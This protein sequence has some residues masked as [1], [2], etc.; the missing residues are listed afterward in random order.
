MKT[1]THLLLLAFSFHVA[2]AQTFPYDVDGQSYR[3]TVSAANYHLHFFS[4]HLST[5][6]EDT[7]EVEVYFEELEGVDLGKNS[8]MSYRFKCTQTIWLGSTKVAGR[9]VLP[10]N[11]QNGRYIIYFFKDGCFVETTFHILPDGTSS[12]SSL[13]W[14]ECGRQASKGKKQHRI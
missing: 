5:F 10:T 13:G 1:T 3:D 7:V 8:L 11:R 4:D 2:S 12:R 9:F 14:G 6:G